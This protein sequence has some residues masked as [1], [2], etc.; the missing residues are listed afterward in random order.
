MTP[1]SHH[2]RFATVM[3]GAI[4]ITFMILA[5]VAVYSLDPRIA[6]YAVGA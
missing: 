6:D 4:G 3:W 5:G 1:G 2:R